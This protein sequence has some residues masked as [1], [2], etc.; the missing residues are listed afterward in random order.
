MNKKIYIAC[1]ANV[2]TGGPELLHQL[3]HKL[4]KKGYISYM[5][6]YYRK[7]SENPVHER[8][9]KYNTECVDY[10]ED[11]KN[12]III[13]PE[14]NINLLKK[15]KNI[16]KS[17]WWLSVDNY[18]ISKNSK[19]NKIKTIFGLLNFDYREKDIIHLSQSQYA[20]EFLRQ[21]GIE[22]KN[23]Y[24]LSDY[25]N[26]V[27]IEESKCNTKFEKK[28][29]V[30]YNPKK[31]YEF[32]KKII[33]MSEGLNWVPLENLK[34]EEMSKL[35]MESK[36]YIDFGNH[37]GKDRIPREA[38]ISGCCIITGKR[39][40]AK[41]KEDVYI[42]DEFKFN[43]SEENIDSIISK[44]NYLIENYENETKKFDLYRDRISKEEIVFEKDIDKIFTKII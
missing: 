22:E 33:D 28:N 34:P 23:I 29:N 43:D 7:K 30:L 6:Y 41:Y 36:V 11:N 9:E 18:F 14:V 35:M 15:F 31:G 21:S 37:P 20:I 19:R 2:A 13:V 40:S 5:Y 16:K 26:N 32:T 42:E 10:I 24:Y 38:A 4:R 3:C 8:Y 1:P 12:N 44:I 25:L 39:G 17:I 27:F